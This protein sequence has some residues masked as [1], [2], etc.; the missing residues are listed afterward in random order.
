[1]DSP[2][3]NIDT[4]VIGAGQAGLT[5]SHHLSRRG[6]PHLVLERARVGERWRTE[7]WDSLR[8][9][10]PSSYV[11]LPGFD[12]DGD[13]PTGFMEK[14]SVV[15]VLERYANHISAPVRTG[16]NVRAVE[17][18]DDGGFTVVCDDFVLGADNVVLAT[19]P[20]QRPIVPAVS[21]E[22]PAHLVQ[23]TAS[24]F[25]NEGA[26]P[27]GAVLV[28]GSGGSGVQIAEDLIDAGRNVYLCVGRH[29]RVPR[30]HRGRDI[31][32]WFEDLGMIS[33]PLTTRPEIDHAPL[34]TGVGGGH[35]V[36]LR[37]LIDRG[38]RLLGRLEAV[39]DGELQL[40][41]TLLEDLADGDEALLQTIRGIDAIL[42][43]RGLA[44]SAQ[45][46]VIPEPRPLPP[47]PPL[48]LNIETSG[49]TSVIWATGYGLDFSWV[50]CCD[51]DDAG[52]PV[53]E[54]GITPVSGLYVLG[55]PFLYSARSSVFW[56]VGDDAEYLVEHLAARRAP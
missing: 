34:L 36:D 24:S 32:D 52:A 18:A 11:R 55:L 38:G 4:V 10:F 14:D 19:G 56:G 8:F 53:N 54:R 51:F 44:D 17:H 15:R 37:D 23:L 13:D 5:M 31:T 26:L 1:M 20:Y 27:A 50:H 22:L 12:Y 25:T 16:V 28:V 2:R 35:D 40:G 49:I 9:Q 33:A 30:R 29:R 7:R 21:T 6:I 48:S 42:A 46:S 41:A 47:E 39:A 45:P 3:T 43:E